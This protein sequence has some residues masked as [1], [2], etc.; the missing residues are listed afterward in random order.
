M[1]EESVF[2][3]KEG[4]ARD[5]SLPGEKLR[6]GFP[7]LQVP[8]VG[9]TACCLQGSRAEACSSSSPSLSL[10]FFLYVFYWSAVDLGFP[11]SSD[12][13][14][15]ACNTGDL[16][17]IPGLGRS[18]GRGHGNPLQYSSLEKPH[19][20]RSLAG[21][22]PWGHKE[23]DM[24]EQLSTADLQHFRCT[25]RWFVHT[26]IHILFLELFSIIGYYKIWTH[27]SLCYTI[28]F[29]CLLHIYF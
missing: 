9:D 8:P 10:S 1:P 26:Y 16:G 19:G 11:G 4:G 14:E 7:S 27:S 15:S 18:P 12:G 20:Q 28:S 21:C 23:L 2:S 13:K 25:A 29:C 5:K 17:S 6:Q 22:S 3:Q 24:T